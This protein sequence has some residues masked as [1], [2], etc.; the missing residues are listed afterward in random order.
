MFVCAFVCSKGRVRSSQD[1]D[2][3]V[4]F[5]I[6]NTTDPDPR[7][8]GGTDLQAVGAVAEHDEAFEE[9]LREAGL[10]RLLADDDGAQLWRVW[11]C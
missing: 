11:V 4:F 1:D 8:D 10:G 3:G 7:T 6:F 5:L 9:G 2:A